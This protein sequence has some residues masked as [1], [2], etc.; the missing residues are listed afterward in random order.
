M[1][2]L[3]Q[4][5]LTLPDTIMTKYRMPTTPTTRK[6]PNASAQHKKSNKAVLRDLNINRC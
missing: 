4:V 3:P 5:S 1:M 2:E 6:Q